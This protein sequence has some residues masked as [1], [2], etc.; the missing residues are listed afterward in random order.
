MKYKNKLVNQDEHKDFL[1]NAL[2]LSGSITPKVIKMVLLVII[3]SCVITYIHYLR[4]SISLPIGPFEYTG[5]ILGLIL[6][7]RVNSGYDRWWEA[8]KIW[9]SIINQSRNLTIILTNYSTTNDALS[10]TKITNYV[11]ALPFLMKNHLRGDETMEQIKSLIDKDLFVKLSQS[12]HKVNILSST[13]AHA[14]HDLRQTNELDSFSFLQAEEK[15]ADLIDSHGACERILKTPMPFV[16]A[17]KTR[18]FIFLF[19]LALPLA[20]VN[21]SVWLN[22]L[23]TGLVAYAILS[24]DQ[25]GIE[26]QSPF[27]EKSLSHLPLNDICDN[28]KKNI[29]EIRQNTSQ[30]RVE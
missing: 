22:P 11:A 29:M 27:S 3:Y 30:M 16:M 28:I 23:I 10:Q 12:K 17:L 6:V 15:R 7:F 5:L 24:L 2:T 8:R 14:L 18:Q 21:I 9:G 4:P 19:L 20:L 1:K 26:L 13:I 25:I